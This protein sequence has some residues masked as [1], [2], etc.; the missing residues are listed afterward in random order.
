MQLSRTYTPSLSKSMPDIVHDYLLENILS[1]TFRP[2]QSLKQ[3]DVANHLKISRSAVRE[4]LNRLEGDGLAV[5]R[6]RR[7]YVV[8]SLE[9]DEIDEI[10]R[11]RMLLEEHAARIAAK[12][13]TADDI[14]TVKKLM[15]AMDDIPF[16][17]PDRSSKWA[18]LNRE[19]HA[20]IFKASRQNWLC[21]ITGNLRDVVEL[22]VRLDTST[23]QAFGAAGSDHRQIVGAF[24]AG[25]AELA[26][27]LSR[28][29]VQ[30]TYERLKKSIDRISAEFN[31]HES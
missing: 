3:D 31:E 20:A 25:D 14:A 13:R 15:Q 10:F 7:G 1:G 6:P 18:A 4:A 16:D 29:H 22:Y 11:I 28:Q 8:A 2:G 30:N 26:A 5:L 24:E 9:R 12:R 17:A 27:S 21:Q 19:F 23:A